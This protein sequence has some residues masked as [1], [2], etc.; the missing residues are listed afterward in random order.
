MRSGV[1]MPAEASLDRARRGI[2][3]VKRKIKTVIGI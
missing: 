3:K 1:L 2:Q